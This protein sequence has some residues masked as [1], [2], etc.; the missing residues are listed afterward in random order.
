[1]NRLRFLVL[2]VVCLIVPA[3]RVHSAPV[4]A[5][6]SGLE[7]VPATAPLVIHVRGIK[8]AHDRLV[9]LMK[10][11]LP[12]LYDKYKSQI[13]EFFEKGPDNALKSRKLVGL[14]DDGP[15]FLAF[16]ELPK[17]SGG[18]PK[19]AFI[20]AVKNYKEFHDGFLTEEERKNS[21]DEGNGIESVSIGSDSAFF[22]DRKAYAVVTPDKES[23]ETFTKKITGLDTKIS[24]EQ[25]AK[26]LASDLGLY[27]NMDAVN[28]EYGDQIKQ[29]KQTIEQG[30]GFAVAAGGG[31]ESAKKFAEMV[32]TALPHIFQTIEDLQSLI[33]TFELRTG[34]LALHLQSD[35]RESST[36]A[37]YLQDSRPVAFKELNRLPQDFAFYL[38]M[39][40][41]S[42]LLKN[43]GGLFSG[44]EGGESQD[45][46]ELMKELAKA[47]PDIVLSGGS[48]PAP[49]LTVYHFDKPAQ[50][51]AAILK[52]YQKMEPESNKLKEK[53]VVKADA[54]KHG[55]FTLHSV[56]LAF[57]LDKMAEAAA[58][59]G[60][61][62]AKKATI[63]ALKT[64]VGEKKTM[65]FGTDGKTCVQI[66]ASDWETARKMLDQYSKGSG[67]AGDAKTF[68]ELR[69]E[70]PRQASFLVMGDLVRLSKFVVD[71]VK[72]QLPPGVNVPADWPNLSA[73][74]ALAYIGLALTLQPNRGG[75]DLFLTAD[76]AGEFYKVVIKPLVGE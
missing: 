20:L 39:K 41:G 36:T 10:K 24:K 3:S 44:L 49:G 33:L 59:K 64:I 16:L 15:L 58:A 51:V 46:A 34:G 68:R 69:K 73:K 30:L 62:D 63:E 47:G 56:Q 55:D 61:D 18:P 60:G 2:A 45:A 22:V 8:G 21:K 38:G 50:A 70:M 31:D 76:A 52:M 40:A 1:M 12:N 5:A 43:L 67:T 9:S 7:Q 66:T 19:M 37:N 25:T 42:G 28:K 32:K 17:D 72:P 75:L 65:W 74:G 4:P 6:H 11:A 26:L 54:Q 27:V 29:F 23:A 71:I 13:D 35:L 48:L 53:P 14:A 57:D